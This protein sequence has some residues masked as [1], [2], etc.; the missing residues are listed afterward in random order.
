MDKNDSIE[1]SFA[2]M[3]IEDDILFIT[4][5]EDAEIDVDQIKEAIRGRK[6]I[7]KDLPM[8]TL[9]DIRNLYSISNKARIFAAKNESI[10]ELNKAMAIL[11]SSL[12]T[13]M[14]ANFF[15]KVNKPKTPTKMFDSKEKAL[16]WLKTFKS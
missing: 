10:R 12:A 5:K 14:F 8:L 2:T 3:H 11:T 13:K 6:E 4:L 16:N 15:I 1:I 7:Q 9:T